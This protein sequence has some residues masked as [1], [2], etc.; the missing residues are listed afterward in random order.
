MTFT[1]LVVRFL[2]NLPKA[3]LQVFDLQG[4]IFWSEG[5]LGKMPKTLLRP[6]F[7]PPP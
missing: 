3:D 5:F 1:P 4:V 6:A 7:L 2:G